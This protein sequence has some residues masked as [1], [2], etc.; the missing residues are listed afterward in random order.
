MKLRR[1]ST[2]SFADIEQDEHGLILRQTMRVGRR[3]K[4]VG[5]VKRFQREED[6]LIEIMRR[7]DERLAQLGR[8]KLEP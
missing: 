3:S 2:F 5:K 7:A 4:P 1:G 6:L 8:E